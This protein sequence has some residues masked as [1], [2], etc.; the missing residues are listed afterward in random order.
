MLFSEAPFTGRKFKIYL[1][2]ILNHL[3][4]NAVK[5]YE[6]FANNVFHLW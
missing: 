4:L 5:T 3:L 2:L 1:R 6:I